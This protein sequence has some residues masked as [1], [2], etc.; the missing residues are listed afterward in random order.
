MNCI[1]LLSW[2]IS[3]FLKSFI[4]PYHCLTNWGC[5]L[6]WTSYQINTLESSFNFDYAFADLVQL[7]SGWTTSC[8]RKRFQQNDESKNKWNRHLMYKG[9]LVVLKKVFLLCSPH[10]LVTL[11][12]ALGFKNQHSTF[13]SANNSRR[14][15]KLAS[16]WWNKWWV[17]ADHEYS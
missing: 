1:V 13:C 17:A 7:T 10:V 15:L 8:F 4:A 14:I 5:L 2:H 9:E 16:C 3:C 11:F 6:A 12:L